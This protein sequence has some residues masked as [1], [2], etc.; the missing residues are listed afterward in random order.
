MANL[1]RFLDLE[2]S[3]AALDFGGRK[4]RSLGYSSAL[5]AVEEKDCAEVLECLPPRYL[6]IFQRPPYTH[7]AWSRRFSR[8][9]PIPGV[10]AQCR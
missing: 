8:P 6:E 5:A 9:A 7:F 1:L 3:Q 10:P 2:Q 4:N